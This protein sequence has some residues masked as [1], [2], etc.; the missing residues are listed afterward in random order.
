[1]FLESRRRSETQDALGLQR[2]GEQVRKCGLFKPYFRLPVLG[3]ALNELFHI[4][5]S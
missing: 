4:P 3:K 2:L 1:M 5:A